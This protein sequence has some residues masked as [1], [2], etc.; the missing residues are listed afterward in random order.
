MSAQDIAT[1]LRELGVWGDRP[2]TRDGAREFRQA[3]EELGTTYIK[4]GQLLSSRPELMP[5]VYIEELSHLTDDA[6]PLPFSEVEP[7][8]AQDVGLDVFSRID[9]EPLASASIAQVHRALMRDGRD[10]VVKVRRPGIEEQVALDLD[11][12][13]STAALLERRS[14]T[15]R[16]VQAR[17]LRALRRTA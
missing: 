5:D 16:A 8:I 9:P 7:A 12:L 2:A 17:A 4:L 6:P 14:E 13:R 15:A 1:V 3:P 11:L 10:V